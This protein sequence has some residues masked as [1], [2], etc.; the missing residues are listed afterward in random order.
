MTQ[1]CIWPVSPTASISVPAEPLAAMARGDGLAGG[2]PPVFGVL[3][4]PA[5]VF[6]VDGCVFAGEGG[7]DPA[8]A[9]DQQRA[10]SAG[11]NIDS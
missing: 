10:G 11:S 6:G 9:V 2:A 5:D 7:D 3:L 8:G 4:G 1:P